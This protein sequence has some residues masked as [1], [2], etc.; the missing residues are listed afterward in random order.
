METRQ[1]DFF[2]FSVLFW[3]YNNVNIQFYLGAP[4]EFFMLVMS[5]FLKHLEETTMY[6]LG[7]FHCC[8]G[9]C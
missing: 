5:V 6:V 9:S 8:P 4:P 2:F 1:F 7:S 3:I